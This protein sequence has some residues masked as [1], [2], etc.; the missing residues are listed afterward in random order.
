MAS[1]PAGLSLIKT[2][3]MALGGTAIAVII[4]LAIITGFKNTN[5]TDNTTA[6]AFIT[7]LRIFGTFAGVVAIGIMGFGLFKMFGTGKKSGL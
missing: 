5:L 4:V 7:S 2:G 6:D 1:D 3:A